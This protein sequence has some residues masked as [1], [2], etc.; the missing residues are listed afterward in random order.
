M[1]ES[2]SVDVKGKRD[3]AEAGKIKLLNPSTGEISEISL[4][5]RLPLEANRSL[6]LMP[7]QEYLQQ[8]LMI[9]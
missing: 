3:I 2:L 5:A 9:K 6:L 1:Q 7:G 4:P 8:G